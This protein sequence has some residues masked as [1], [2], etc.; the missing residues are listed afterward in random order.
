MAA[1]S[2]AVC[3]LANRSAGSKRHSTMRSEVTAM[4]N[5]NAAAKH[6]TA[7]PANQYAL[8]K[9]EP[10]RPLPHTISSDPLGEAS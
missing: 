9:D 7:G 3:A 10:D 4:E 6:R 8:A 2:I 5:R 1:A